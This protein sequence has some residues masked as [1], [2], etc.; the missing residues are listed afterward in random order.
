MQGDLGDCWLLAAMSSLAMNQTLLQQVL[1]PGQGFG[2]EEYVGM[3]RF[4]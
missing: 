1:P 4:R 3:F 2:T